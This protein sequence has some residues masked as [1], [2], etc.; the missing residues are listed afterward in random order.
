MR[1]FV[2]TGVVVMVALWSPGTISP[3]GAA[4]AQ[5]ATPAAGFTTPDPGECLIESRTVA[6][7][8]SFIPSGGATPVAAEASPTPL[9][10][11]EGEPADA[12]AAT[13]VTATAEELIACYNANDFLRAFA[14]FTDD[15]VRR[16]IIDDD[17]TAEGIGLLAASLE[18]RAAPDRQSVAVQDIR[19]LP[20]GH[21]TAV[22]VIRDPVADGIETASLAIFVQ[23][24]GRYL[25]DEALF[26]G[27]QPP[28]T[29]QP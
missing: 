20:D 15:Y 27:P 11:P 17:V 10:T 22:L 24:E 1:R 19:V 25:I 21:I 12:D 2:A 16:S 3:P 5:T 18:P 28:A 8:I 14:L 6:E 9:V 26:L 29:P 13:G 4:A 23:I 7:L